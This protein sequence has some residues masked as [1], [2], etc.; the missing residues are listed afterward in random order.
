MV[1]STAPPNPIDQFLDKLPS[2]TLHEILGN[3]SDASNRRRNI[4]ISKGGEALRI[5]KAR[6]AVLGKNEKPITRAGLV[7][8]CLCRQ[9]Q[10]GHPVSIPVQTLSTVLNLK[11]K[12]NVEQMQSLVSSHL[13][14]Y[15]QKN[16]GNRRGQKRKSDSSS[17]RGSEVTPSN[18]NS[19]TMS[20]FMSY[21]RDLCIRLG[22][23]I[24]NAEMAASHAQKLF[25]TLTSTSIDSNNKQH[26]ML[27]D[28]ISRNLEH[29]EAACLF[30]AVHRIEGTEFQ[31]TKRQSNHAQKKKGSKSSSNREE[32]YGDDDENSEESDVDENQT[33][34]ES[35][36]V[37]A[38]N[39]REGL[40][41]QILD[42]V[43]EYIEDV[44]VP[45][46]SSTTTLSGVVSSGTAVHEPIINNDAAM[47]VANRSKK[48][49]ASEKFTRWKQD[50]LQKVYESYSSSV[51]DEKEIL[52]SAADDV[53]RQF[54]VI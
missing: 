22:P 49:K 25:H 33:L 48:K 10:F 6:K 1:K 41:T 29:Y 28:D 34:T 9:G 16:N 38:A 46:S 40:F 47:D 2:H 30:L 12:K 15:V 39:L 27:M 44:E 54:G 53:L 50:R 4:I 35:L 51:S 14:S 37:N 52:Q 23:M 17:T 3:G 31:K 11:G 5:L 21:A 24:P 43:N 26:S 18:D 13:E 20:A 45:I 19:A 7:V 42:K 36:I 8:D 32:L